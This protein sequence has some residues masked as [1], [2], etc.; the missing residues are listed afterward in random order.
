MDQFLNEW[1]TSPQHNHGDSGTTF[2]FRVIPAL[3][4]FAFNPA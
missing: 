2:P 3:G 4:Q 1:V